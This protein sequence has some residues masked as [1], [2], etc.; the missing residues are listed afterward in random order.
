[1]PILCPTSGINHAVTLV[2]YGHDDASGKDYWIVKNSWG[3]SWGESGYFRIKRG[4]GTCGVNCY[5]IT[6]NVSF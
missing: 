3:V 2:G 1:M 6:G 4:S 5:V